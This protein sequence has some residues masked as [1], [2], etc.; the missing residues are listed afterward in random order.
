[1]AYAIW[2]P[3]IWLVGVGNY[4]G[5]NNNYA[6][7]PTMKSTYSNKHYS[8]QNNGADPTINMLSHNEQCSC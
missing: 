8:I 1:M 4:V 3:I 2:S 6:N 5:P 7:Y